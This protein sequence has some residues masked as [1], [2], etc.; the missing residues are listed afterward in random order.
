MLKS[1]ITHLDS[2]NEG[3]IFKVPC[4]KQFY[5]VKRISLSTNQED[6]QSWPRQT[7]EN[8]TK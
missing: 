1:T 6:L 5:V 4:N 7:G 2:T 3:S 8:G